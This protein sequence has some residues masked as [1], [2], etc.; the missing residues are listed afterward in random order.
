[1]I[2][3]AARD[4]QRPPPGGQWAQPSDL[5]AE[6]AAAK[7]ARDIFTLPIGVRYLERLDRVRDWASKFH[8][9]RWWVSTNPRTYI[10]EHTAD[11]EPRFA[12]LKWRKKTWDGM[13]PRKG[14]PSDID[15]NPQWTL[16]GDWFADGECKALLNG[17]PQRASWHLVD[18]GPDLRVDVYRFK[19]EQGEWL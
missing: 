7:A 11:E 1:M 17:D 3:T 14:K 9:V 19:H 16:T 8:G 18:L 6:Y 15:L 5:L 12:R 13:Y 2:D 10:D 4:A